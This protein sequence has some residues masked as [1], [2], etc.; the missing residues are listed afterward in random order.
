MNLMTEKFASEVVNPVYLLRLP[1]MTTND[2]SSRRCRSAPP[3]SCLYRRLPLAGGEAR[4]LRAENGEIR[5]RAD[6][7]SMDQ[8]L[9]MLDKANLDVTLAI[10]QKAPFSDDNPTDQKVSTRVRGSVLQTSQTSLREHPLGLEYLSQL[11]TGAKSELA[12]CGHISKTLADRLFW[13]FGLW[14]SA[15]AFI[16]DALNRSTTSP[17]L[18]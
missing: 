2:Q 12:S 14:D 1:K 17:R 5:K 11:L 16:R 8:T 3:K 4:V 7:L 9:R 13:T 10:Y 18:F 6:T 15:L